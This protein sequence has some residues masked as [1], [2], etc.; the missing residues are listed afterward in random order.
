MPS[1][2]MDI[3]LV[4]WEAFGDVAAAEANV[5]WI[6]AR[7]LVTALEIGAKTRSHA[8]RGKLCAREKICA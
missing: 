6:A 8:E 7:I 3:F 5:R 1:L 2:F 4:A